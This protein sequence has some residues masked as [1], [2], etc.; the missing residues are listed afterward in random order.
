M[1]DIKN[2]IVSIQTRPSGSCFFATKN[3]FKIFSKTAGN[4]LTDPIPCDILSSQ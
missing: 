3:N 1:I 4:H 2:C